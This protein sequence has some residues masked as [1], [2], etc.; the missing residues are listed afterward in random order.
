MTKRV[1]LYGG[2]LFDGENLLDCGT[3]IFRDGLIEDV[4]KGDCHKGIADCR[5]VAGKLIAP[6]LVD[7]HSDALE[8]CIE[9]RPG[10]YFDS[11]FALHSLDQRLAGFGITTFCHGIS[12]ADTED[13]FSVRSCYEAE[14]LARLVKSFSS[15]GRASVRH[16]LHIRYEI[17]SVEA[18]EMIGRLI[19]E[20]LVDMVSL[21]DHTPGQGQFKTM[22]AY[23][24]YKTSTYKVT[25]EQAVQIAEQKYAQRE[26][27]L[28]HLSRVAEKVCRSGIPFLSHDDDTSEKVNFVRGL[29]VTGSEFP[30][31]M[32]AVE[33]AKGH[34]MSVFMGA[35]NLFRD[36]STNG[37]VK[38]SETLARGFCDALVSDY[39]VECL[40]HVPFLAHKR[41]SMG[42]G[43]TLK[44]VTS[45]PG[46]FLKPGSRT[47]TLAPGAP[48]DLIVIDTSTPWA[49]VEQ[50]WVS[51]ELKLMQK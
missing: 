34:G 35:P 16:L 49:R 50:T 5:D 12:F 30:V 11:E 45:N 20:G 9:M 43:C 26:K 25:T 10:V 17:T 42:L 46:R 39:Y 14:R 4:I 18:F 6:G 3:V 51:G 8:K 41:Y 48:A 22:E 44:L 37:H 27:G 47:G 33:T 32:E 23:V 21:M 24:A 40:L 36:R 31:S 29:G 2:P 1:C 7:L 13:V 38:A 19:G 28:L 15:S